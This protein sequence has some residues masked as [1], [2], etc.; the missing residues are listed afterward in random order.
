M[1]HLIL[2]PVFVLLILTLISLFISIFSKI[3][4]IRDGSLPLA[5]INQLEYE[6]ASSESHH[7]KTTAYHLYDLLRMPILFYFNV[8][9]INYLNLTDV[10]FAIL[11]SLYV[12]SILLHS[13]IFLTYNRFTHRLS[14]FLLA[15]S[16][17]SV[18]IILTLIEVIKS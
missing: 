8:L 4:A 17:L 18:M 1:Q 14:I 6:R 10:L 16:F 15:N 5:N 11:S 9:L 3:Q 13:I 7:A 2:Y 12:A